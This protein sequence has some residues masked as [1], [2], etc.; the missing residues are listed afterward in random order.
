MLK[1]YLRLFLKLKRDTSKG[2]PAPH[3]PILLLAIIQL[4]ERGQIVENTITI[5]PELVAEYNDLFNLFADVRFMHNFAL[6]FY[7]LQSSQFWHVKT[8]EGK[9][10]ALTSSKS[11]KS[12][13]H[14]RDVVAYARFD[15]ALWELLFEN[16]SRGILKTA[17]LET[18]FP[19]RRHLIPGKQPR[20]FD[21][22]EELVLGEPEVAWQ[23]QI[24]ITDPEIAFV[25][26][27]VF[28]RAIPRAYNHTCCISGMR[29]TST[30]SVQM[31]DACHIKPIAESGVDHIS[32]GISL[33]PNLHRAFD[34]FLITIS[35]D[36]V[37]HI[38]EDLLEDGPYGIRQFAGKKIILPQE[39]H[40]HP[41]P[42]YLDWHWSA[43][44][45]NS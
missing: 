21:E 44:L 25:R 6:P 4:I 14:L 31:I 41:L 32:N 28:K 19:D 35:P 3:K 17:L 39:R 1:H 45:K 15:E 12:F 10:I 43:Y 9:E 36:F 8:Y 42:E 24:Q 16:E 29:L 18:Y 40:N 38:S 27:G 7:H 30:R 26:G 20:L 34:R 33:C 13:S 2:L 23:S 37:V 22:L 11:I 5:S